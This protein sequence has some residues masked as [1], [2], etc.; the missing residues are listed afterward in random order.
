MANLKQY[1]GVSAEM[2]TMHPHQHTSQ[3]MKEN[4]TTEHTGCSEGTIFYVK[5]GGT[6]SDHRALKVSPAGKR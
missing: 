5:P 3:A 1:I 4:H 6:Y 2:Q